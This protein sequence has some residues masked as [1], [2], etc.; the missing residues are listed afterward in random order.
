MAELAGSLDAKSGANADVATALVHHVE[1]ACQHLRIADE[2]AGRLRTARAG[3]QLGQ[4]LS[5]AGDRVG[6]VTALA[7]AEL[8]AAEAVLAMSLAQASGVSEALRQFRW[9]RLA[10][11]LAAEKRTDQ[12]GRAAASILRDLRAAV[13]ADEFTVRLP[14]A[15][16]VAEQAVF[17]WLADNQLPVPPPPAPPAPVQQ[18]GNPHGR[19]IVTRGSRPDETIAELTA[20]LTKHRDDEVVVEW[21]VAE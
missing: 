19:A 14:R 10:P 17:D 11:L 7:H 5:R 2:A 12:R 21:R 4:Q 13:A 9:E 16:S 18:P 1:V 20:F 3:A 6:M 8:P 15:L